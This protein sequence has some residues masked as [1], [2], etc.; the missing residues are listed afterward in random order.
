MASTGFGLMLTEIV[1]R[2]D[3]GEMGLVSAPPPDPTL[4]RAA[5]AK[6]R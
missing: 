4:A 6:T 1:A 2:V 5:H 3:D